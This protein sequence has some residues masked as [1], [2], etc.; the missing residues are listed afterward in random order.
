MSIHR[1]DGLIVFVCDEC[2]EQ[3]ETDTEEFDEARQ[4]M[5]EA[6]WTYRKDDGGQ[7]EH[8]CSIC[9]PF[10]RKR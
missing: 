9:K 10:R 5:Q 4:Q 2:G 6:N 3:L 1:E 8:Y 7:W